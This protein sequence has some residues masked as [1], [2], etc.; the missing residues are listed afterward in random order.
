MNLVFELCGWD[1]PAF[2][3]A[4]EDYREVFPVATTHGCYVVDGQFTDAVPDD[5]QEMFQEFQWVQY[6]WRNEFIY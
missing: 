5:R 2:M 3:Q 1:G 4:M 6:Y